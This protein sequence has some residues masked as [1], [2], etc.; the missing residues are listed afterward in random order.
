MKWKEREG[1]REQKKWERGQ[2]LKRR[3]KIL[4]KFK[5]KAC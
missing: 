2:I 5:P 4:I 3:E 1:K